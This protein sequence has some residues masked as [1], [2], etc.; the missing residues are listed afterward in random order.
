[1]AQA[2]GIDISHHQNTGI[3]WQ[4]V[5]QSGQR[6]AFIRASLV[7]TATKKPSADNNFERHWTNARAVNGLLLGTYHYFLPVPDIKEQIDFFLNIVGTRKVDL[8]LALDFENSLGV[9]KTT[10][11]RAIDDA[12]KYLQSKVGYRPLIYTASSWWNSNTIASPEWSKYDLWIANYGKPAPTLPR[13]WMAYRF[14]QWTQTG[15]VAGISGNVDVDYYNGD[16]TQLR[17]YAASHS[18]PT[19]APNGY[20]V[21]VTTTVNI[22]KG[23]GTN[24]EIAGSL[25]AGTQTAVLD[26]AGGDIWMQIGSNR[27]AAYTSGG[28]QLCVFK[29]GTPPQIVVAVTQMNVRSGPSKSTADVGDLTLGTV[30]NVTDLSGTDIWVKIGDERWA[31]FAKDSTRFMRWLT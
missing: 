31:A 7:G 14:W 15:S 16:E 8:P 4:Q 13:D 9:D 23:P 25:K 22:R 21:E 20:R 19:P 12:L 1:M 2:S 30:L 5:Y 17:L 26:L 10:V 29:A 18:T 27:W 24:Y 6:F 11:S 28:Q 3:N